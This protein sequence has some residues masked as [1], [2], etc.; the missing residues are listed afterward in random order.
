ML[1]GKIAESDFAADLAQVLRGDAPEEYADPVRFFANTYPTRGLKNLMLNVCLRLYGS[2]LSVASILRLDTNYGGGKTHGLIALYHAARGMTG[3]PNVAEFIDPA[4]LSQQTVRIAAFDG[5]NADPSNGRPLGDGLRAYTP[6]G[7]LAYGLAGAEGYERVRRS[8]EDRVAPGADTIRELFGNQ[9]TLILIDELSVYLRKLSAGDRVKAGGQLTAF[10]TG[11]FK[12]VESSPNAVLVYTLALGKDRVAIDAYSEENQFI[13][14]KM[15][16]AE[17]VSARK[18]ALLDPTE[19]DETV[20]VLRRRLFADIDDARAGQVIESYHRLWEQQREH[21]PS[22]GAQDTRLDAFKAG[23]PLHPE[24]IETLKEKTSTLNNF[25]RVR[26]ML[27]ILARTVGSLWSTRPQDAYAVH[28]HHIDLR[29]SPIRQEIVT[30]LGQKSFVPALKADVAAVEGDQPSMAQEM[31]AT[32]YLGLPPYGSYV[33]RTI[34]FHTL[35]YH[36]NLKGLSPEELRYAILSPG[37]DISFVDDA[38]RRFVQ[39]S[40]YLDDRPNAPLRFLNEANLTQMIRRQER[41]V[42]PGEVRSQLNDRI[43]SIFNGTTFQLAAFP[44]IPNEVPDESGNGKPTLAVINYDADEVDG[45]HVALPGLVRKLYRERGAAGDVRR[46]RNNLV[47]VVVDAQRKADMKRKMVRRLALEDL[48]RPERLNDL[49]EHQQDRLKE[50]YQRSE[51]ELALAIQ[52]AY[53]HVFYSSRNRVEGADVELSHSS[54]EVQSASANPGDGQR[55]VVR[56]LRSIGKLRLPEDD[57]D[58]AAYIRDR[59]PLKKGQISTAALRDEFRRDPALP[60]LVGDDVFFK[61]IRQGIESGELIYRSGDLIW[62]KGDPWAEIKIDEQSFVHT[63]EYAKG[64]NIWPR[65]ETRTETG[66][67]T[68]TGTGMDSDVGIGTG[69]GSETGAGL[70][71]GRGSDHGAGQG[72]GLGSEGTPPTE[73]SVSAEGVL[74]EALARIWEMARSRKFMAIAV[75]QLTIYNLSDG[76]KLLGLINAIPNSEKTVTIEGDYVTA[77]GSSMSCEFSGSILDAHPVKDFLEAQLRAA[78]DKNGKVG[79]E[80]RFTEPLPLDQGEPEKLT[81]RLLRFGAGAAYVTAI[82]EDAR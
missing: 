1:E 50:W 26:G 76:F 28:L 12:A 43:K 71:S 18:A 45:E 9:P 77:Q 53:R 67:S 4:I 82:A 33:G 17:S 19:E 57:P 27:R 31:D 47:F 58:S 42:D 79:F 36:D 44:S 60:I 8:D 22:F 66:T 65:P 70:G 32:H 5:E 72:T 52:Q 46:N 38:L 14:E 34:F 30:K 21:L 74:R 75:L 56:A 15:E 3:V 2:G 11:L 49:A 20:Q 25:Q 7:E 62:G 81:E 40:A 37:T 41:Q 29:S 54:V 10:L 51:Q 68:G 35:A 64:Q 73:R 80:I 61:G 6:W 48:R 69:G 13:A 63:M 55:Q 24:L 39:V 59:T 23:Y 78:T 16:E